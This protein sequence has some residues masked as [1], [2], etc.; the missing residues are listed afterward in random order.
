MSTLA[1]GTGRRNDTARSI[2][3]RF[4]K[5][6]VFDLRAVTLA[7]EDMHAEFCYLVLLPL[8]TTC[9]ACGSEHM[10]R[11]TPALRA[12]VAWRKHDG[13]PARINYHNLSLLQL[14]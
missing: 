12:D 13:V 8:W 14:L 1:H 10:A 4:S 3:I 2:L 9:H 7:S 6:V 5:W 11:Y